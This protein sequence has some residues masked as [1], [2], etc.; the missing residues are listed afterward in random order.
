MQFEFGATH[1]PKVPTFPLPFRAFVHLFANVIL[2][3]VFFS[4]AF[5]LRH[6]SLRKLNKGKISI[7]YPFNSISVYS[8][9]LFKKCKCSM[10]DTYTERSLSAPPFYA[11]DDAIFC[12]SFFCVPYRHRHFHTECQRTQMWSA[13]WWNAKRMWQ[14]KYLLLLGNENTT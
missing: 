12:S 1:P 13:K 8:A 2:M 14:I 5:L 4:L 10:C 6:F 3:S 9:E 11:I 7:H